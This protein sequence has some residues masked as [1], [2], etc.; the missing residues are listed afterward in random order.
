MRIERTLT[1]FLAAVALC[2]PS[3]GGA[4]APAKPETSKSDAKG[5]AA[6]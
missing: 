3:M 4:Q 5:R 6:R 2:L 1:A